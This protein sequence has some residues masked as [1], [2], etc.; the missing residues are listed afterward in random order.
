MPEPQA[1]AFSATVIDEVRRIAHRELARH[2]RGLTLETRALVNEVYLKLHAHGPPE[3]A[4]RAHLIATAAQAVRQIIIDHARAR[5]AERRGGGAAAVSL[6]VL[7]GMGYAVDD[8]E[9]WLRV[10]QAMRRLGERDARLEQVAEL[11]YFAGLE[12]EEVAEVLGISEAT[13]K[14]DARLVR[15]FLAAELG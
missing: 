1:A 14:R 13:V 11:R 12:V 6:A 5:Q 4:N 8:A 3:F 7:D 2:Q 10:D 9:Q 15:A